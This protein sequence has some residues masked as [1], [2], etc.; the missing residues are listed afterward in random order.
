MKSN[1]LLTTMGCIF[2]LMTF[3]LTILMSAILNGYVL[4]MMWSQFIVPKFHIVPLNIVESMLL[5]MVVGFLTSKV[6]FP[7]NKDD[8]TKDEKLVD[9]ISYLIAIVIQ[10]IITMLIFSIIIL[11]K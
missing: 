10:P 7:K 4:S 8:R 9:A 1:N 3:P 6:S 11:F 2:M 5:S